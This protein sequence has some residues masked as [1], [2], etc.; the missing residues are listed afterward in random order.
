MTDH[1]EL[2]ARLRAEAK[3]EAIKGWADPET[4]IEAA[5]ALEAAQAVIA[6]M[7]EDLTHLHESNHRAISKADA[8]VG[9]LKLL[10][11]EHDRMGSMLDG[12]KRA[13]AQAVEAERKAC[14]R[15]AE[16]SGDRGLADHV[17]LAEGIACV[18]RA[19]SKGD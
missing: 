15:I 5:D 16:L 1:V 14:A 10:T 13:I 19:R 2:I 18:I 9:E 11:I 7:T 17:Q 3:R 12:M 6:G 4:Y 8:A